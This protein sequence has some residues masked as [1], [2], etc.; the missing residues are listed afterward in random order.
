[1]TGRLRPGLAA[2]RRYGPLEVATVLLAASLFLTL[3]F[4]GSTTLFSSDGTTPVPACNGVVRHVSILCVGPTSTEF[5]H[6][7][8]LLLLVVPAMVRPRSVVAVFAL[9]YAVLVFGN[10]T[11]VADGGDHAAMNLGVVL[12]LAR[13]FR[14]NPVVVRA[15]V[16]VTSAFVFL[17]YFQA[18]IGKLGVQEWGD[19]TAV[20][21]Y[22]Q[23]GA[24]SSPIPGVDQVMSVAASTTIGV[25]A[26]TWG[27]LIAEAFLAAGVFIK[28][29]QPLVV[30]L[31]GVT[32]HAVFAL[33][34]GL[35]SFAL[36]MWAAL[37]LYCWDWDKPMLPQM[38]AQ[39][40]RPRRGEVISHV[41]AN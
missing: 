24:F 38:A 13:C 3:L 11:Y 33:T 1:M 22:I 6:L 19:G 2:A 34:L 8:L 39:Y 27:T 36:S 5:A 12:V 31:V 7:L 17:I 25:A 40:R 23:I 4:N 28:R 35:F 32:L 15:L 18:G 29:T 30:F 21:Y 9:V 14:S 10:G 41:V 20:Y 37:C 16:L 26:M